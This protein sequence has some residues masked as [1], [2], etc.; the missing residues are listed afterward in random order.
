[1]EEKK[2]EPVKPTA[3][4]A[5]TTAG[6]VGGGSDLMDPLS[7]SSDP[8]SIDLD[9]LSLAAATSRNVDKVDG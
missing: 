9:P 8:L 3:K 6:S 7:S 4:A 2:L 1:M 5:G